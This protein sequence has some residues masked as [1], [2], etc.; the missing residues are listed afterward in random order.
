MATPPLSWGPE[1]VSLDPSMNAIHKLS[2]GIATIILSYLHQNNFFLLFVLFCFVLFCFVL[3]CFVLFCFVL[4]CF[5][6]F[7]LL[8]SD[9]V[10]L[11]DSLESVMSDMR[12]STFQGLLQHMK[13]ELNDEIFQFYQQVT[14]L[15]FSF[16]FF[17]VLFLFS[18]SP[19][20]RLSSISN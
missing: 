1:L 15:F 16:P 7:C 11:E 8:F 19:S 2:I 12:G 9:S 5:V 17:F 20:L 13:H 18:L 14:F 3:F 4:F 10:T 6:L